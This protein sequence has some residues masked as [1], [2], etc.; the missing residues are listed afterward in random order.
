MNY[1][2]VFEATPNPYLILSPAPG[3]PIVAVN[4][5][6]LKATMTTRGQLVGQNLF[7]IF[8]DRPEMPDVDGVENLSESLRRVCEH[9][10]PDVMAVQRYDIRNPEDQWVV[11]YWRPLNLPVLVAGELE[12]IVHNAEDVTALVAVTGRKRI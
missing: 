2:T 10:A 8:P 9:R 7:D 6:Y 4:D 12:Y 1:R 3:Y 11:R 5:A